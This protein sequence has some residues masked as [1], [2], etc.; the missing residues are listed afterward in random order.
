M[1]LHCEWHGTP[2]DR[3]LK[4]LGSVEV[5]LASGAVIRPLTPRS[6]SDAVACGRRRSTSLRLRAPLMP[7]VRLHN[8]AE[9]PAG[10]FG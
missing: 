5:A 3:N 4:R 6:G 7:A 9:P 8:G 2:Y 1:H 10:T